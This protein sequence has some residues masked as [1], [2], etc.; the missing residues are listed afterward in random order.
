MKTSELAKHVAI[1]SR[2]S[3]V[4][5]ATG[6]VYVPVSIVR[7]TPEE[8]LGIVEVAEQDS[9]D[10]ATWLIRCDIETLNRAGFDGATIAG[11]YRKLQAKMKGDHIG[12]WQKAI[13]QVTGLPLRDVRVRCD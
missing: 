3:V 10:L 1:V 7:D 5:G 12:A 11:R 13:E 4:F 2:L 9:L 8:T 6:P